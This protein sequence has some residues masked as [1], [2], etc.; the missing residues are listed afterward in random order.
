MDPIAADSTL[1]A[2]DGIAALPV[3]TWRAFGRCLR[4]AGLDGTFVRRCWGAPSKSYDTLQRAIRIARTR[5]VDAPA[6]YACRLLML[7]DPVTTAEA[8]TV[9]GPALVDRLVA[10]GLFV[11]PEADRIV[12]AFDCKL[13]MDL[14]VLCDDLTHEGSAVFGAGPGSVAFGS[15]LDN[16]RAIEDALDVGCGAGAVA[17]WIARYARRVVG[18][19]INPRALALLAVNAA[20]NGVGNVEGRHGDLFEPVAGEQFDLIVSQPPFVPCPP[21]TRDATYRF[22]GSNGSEPARHVVSAVPK[23]LRPG[24]RAMIV[25]ELAATADPADRPA[26]PAF[27]VDGTMQA[28]VIVGAEVNAEAYSIRYASAHMRRGIDEFDRRSAAM[29]MHLHDLGIRGMSPAVCVIEHRPQSPG[30]TAT[31]HAGN[32]LWNE[33]SAATIDRLLAGHQLAHESTERLLR[34]RV[35]IPDNALVIRR[36]S[37]DGATPGTVHLGLPPGYLLSSVEFTSSE[38][39]ALESLSRGE[40]VDIAV[41]VV[42]RAARAGLVD[43]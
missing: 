10:A 19:D 27:A 39:A 17:L 15:M 4:D 43:A 20:I 23:H 9:F 25:F 3:D 36:A 35:R 30:W 8:A 26:E 42:G 16:G 21:G 41:D 33:L 40:P 34:A 29:A 6:A 14:V 1:P 31:L 11:R 32:T 38:W 12:S 5:R 7:R 13:F 24:G 22:G 2:I 18:V 28:L 37:A